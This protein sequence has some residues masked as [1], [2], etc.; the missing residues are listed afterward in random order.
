MC[1]RMISLQTKVECIVNAFIQMC[2]KWHVMQ[3]T[4]LLTLFVCLFGLKQNVWMCSI[5]DFKSRIECLIRN[6]CTVLE[7][8]SLVNSC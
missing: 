6:D 8:A 4:P 1:A 2:I 5:L 3:D 7:F